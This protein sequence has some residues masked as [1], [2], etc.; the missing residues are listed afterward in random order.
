M[1]D[2]FSHEYACTVLHSAEQDVL[3]VIKNRPDWQAGKLNFP[4][5]K[6][7]PGEKPLQ[8]ALREL[9]EEA[10]LALM[11]QQM[12]HFLTLNKPGQWR[13]FFFKAMVP[14]HVLYALEA[15]TDERLSVQKAYQILPDF[16]EDYP[17]KVLPCVYGVSMA[18]KLAM[19][20]G[21]ELPLYIRVQ[22]E[23]NSNY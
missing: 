15:G 3:F 4:G 19:T 11:P 17:M 12:T 22:N 9:A 21:L 23:Y 2:A 14:K 18:L 10:K 5:G 20:P 1:T 16:P 6:I 13:V 8:A 7:E